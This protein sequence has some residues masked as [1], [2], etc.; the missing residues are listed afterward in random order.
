MKIG[1]DIDNV[2]S[3][4]NDCL[5]EE[6]K[7]HDKELRNNGIVNEKEYIHKMFDW[8]KEE[9]ETFYYEN[10]ERIAKNLNLIDGAKEYIT[11]LKEDGD[12]IY[13]ISGR[14]NGEYQEPL[15]M[16]EEWLEK[17]K[18]P[19]DSLILT[20]SN[21]KHAKSV[22]CIKNNIDIMIEDSLSV[23]LD[24]KNSGVNVFIMDTPFNRKNTEIERVSSW[25]EIYTKISNYDNK[26]KIKVILD[27]D[28]YNE[29]DDQFALSYLL[30]SQ[31]KFE[32]EAVTIAPFQNERDTKKDSGIS[33]SYEEAQ[34][35]FKLC[36]ENS[37]NKI[38]KGATNYISK[39]YHGTNEA[40]DKIIEIALKNE[41]TYLLGIGAIT[42]IA[43]AIQKEPKI[44]D[45]I[46]V[47]WLGGHTLLKKNN[48]HEANFKD[49]EAVKI[50]FKSKVKLTIIPCK[51]VASNLMTTIYELEN[52]IKGKSELGDFL[53]QNFA[54]YTT[55]ENKNRWP[56][57]DISV[58]AYMLNKDWFETFETNCPDI[59]EDTS[60]QR[61]SNNRII[62][63]V[64]YLDCDKIYEDLFKKLEK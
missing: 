37:E 56:L 5:L 63:F 31:D 42:N 13:I 2:I 20:N 62:T 40:V 43:L 32:I 6:Y 36:N 50:V 39:G 11:K 52:K 1:I 9:E 44:I 8:S 33:R 23:C 64:N 29:C 4:F 14:D 30:K 19:Y 24:L 17:Y 46:E 45:K 12:E 49:V 28:T 18:I 10:I 25:K 22:E 59:N 26:E 48:L 21:D 27:T 41:K 38:W 16:T 60:Y 57:W 55:Y 35:V 34:K 53:Y 54:E 61:N 15:K 7:K 3:N 51:G 58:I 47:I